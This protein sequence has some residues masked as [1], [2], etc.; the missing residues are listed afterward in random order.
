MPRGRLALG[1]GL[2]LL[3]PLALARALPAP[4]SEP[5]RLSEESRARPGYALSQ[6]VRASEAGQ[7]EAAQTLLL[8][9]RQLY[10]IVGDYAALLHVRPA[11]V[12]TWRTRFA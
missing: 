6:A 4:E 11:T 7:H 5:F 3:A 2:V 12:S 1:W 8:M 10:P 9:V